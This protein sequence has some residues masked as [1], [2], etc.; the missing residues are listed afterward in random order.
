MVVAVT[1]A[2]SVLQIITSE[3]AVISWGSQKEGTQQASLDLGTGGGT[4]GVASC[5]G[6]SG[7]FSWWDGTLVQLYIST[8]RELIA[9]GWNR[10]EERNGPLGIK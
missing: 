5:T 7:L 9:K 8:T 1:S 3:G 4:G 10:S 2:A 6:G